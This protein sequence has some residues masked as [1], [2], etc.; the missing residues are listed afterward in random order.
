MDPTGS[1][2]SGNDR[3]FAGPGRD[4]VYAGAGRDWSDGGL[5][6]DR[7]VGASGGDVLTGG[8]GDNHLSGGAGG[9]RLLGD[10]GDD[11]I[12]ARDGGRPPRRLADCLDAQGKACPPL[13]PN[14]DYAEG[15]A[16]DDRILSR[17]GRLDFVTCG[18]GLDVVIAD[19][20]DRFPFRGEPAACEVV[21]T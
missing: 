14:A 5:G 2:V 7:L 6:D 9:D 15:G 11:F 17:D 4:L 18:S 13:P 19:Q 8:P 16:G 1:S 12:N 21:L 3:V 20:R 10:A